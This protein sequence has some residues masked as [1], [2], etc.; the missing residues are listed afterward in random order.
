FQLRGTCA[1]NRAWLQQIERLATYG[2]SEVRWALGVALTAS[3]LEKIGLPCDDRATFP[4]AFSNGMTA[5]WRARAL[6]DR[7]TNWV[8]NGPKS[9]VDVALLL[10]A[11]TSACLAEIDHQVTDISA[12]TAAA[13]LIRSQPMEPLEASNPGQTPRMREP[14]GFTDGIS[15]PVL[16]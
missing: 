7:H 2:T 13:E 4:P 10:C 12:D 5:P 9:Q 11:D 14:F 8:W 15:Q 3:A 16:P 6:G 1:E